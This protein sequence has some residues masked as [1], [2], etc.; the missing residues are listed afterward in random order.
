MKNKFTTKFEKVNLQGAAV[1]VKRNSEIFF[2]L[3]TII[4]GA[5]F[6]FTS[7]HEHIQDDTFIFLRYAQ[8]FV[9]GNGLVFN[10][11][12]YVEGF[13]GFLWLALITVL[14][15]LKEDLVQS[16]TLISMIFG[17]VTVYFAYKLST[18]IQLPFEAKTSEID[19]RKKIASVAFLFDLVPAILLALNG[20]VHYWAG[21][22]METMLYSTFITAGLYYFLSRDVKEKFF[23]YSAVY[24]TLA[25]LS[26]PEGLLVI[27][28]ILFHESVLL[29]SKNKSISAVAKKLSS[30]NYFKFI[31]IVFIPNF[32]L[33]IFR[34]LYYGYPLPNTFYAKAGLSPEYISSGFEYF[35]AFASAYLLWGVLLVFP[36]ILFKRKEVFGKISLLYSIVAVYSVYIIF[37]G[38][39]VLP[40]NRFF[41]PLLPVIYVL[42]GKALLQVYYFLINKFEKSSFVLQVL[43][44]TVLIAALGVYT[45]FSQADYI[46]KKEGLETNLVQKMT[47]SGKW[48]SAK[49]NIAGKPLTVAATTIGALSYYSESIV[50]DMLG[51]TDETIAHN[52]KPIE[53][54]S[55]EY[56]GWKERNYNVEY[57]LS[58]KPD[59]IIF[60][61]GLKPSAFAERALFTSEQFIKEY[62][63]YLIYYTPE[64]FYTNVYKRKPEAVLQ[65]DIIQSNN[66]PNY[67]KNYVN[68]YTE[69]LHVMPNQNLTDK[70][71]KLCKKLETIAPSNFSETYRLLGELY[72]RKGN[73]EEGLKYY[74]HA[75]AIDKFNTTA[76]GSLLGYSISKK[77]TNGIKYYGYILSKINPD[78]LAFYGLN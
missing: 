27:A 38:G 19:K 13:T 40:V 57:I 63:S 45:F 15:F 49:Q 28:I 55:G 68:L 67:S 48:F 54:I 74:K 70:T 61:T 56:T 66:N 16:V 50:I 75:V 3:L 41:I 2:F 72:T 65:A 34:L 9:H 73:E 25:S 78:V 1:S 64:R 33:I 47:A 18:A 58:R 32:L 4:I 77:D 12:E 46:R 44:P 69:I 35:G 76:L 43:I 17:G 23:I 53:E 62:Y 36:L 52:P 71:I 30:G 21:S 20:A 51:L 6:Y 10:P 42:L 29:F 8:N 22:G 59:F 5:Y 26:R 24:L 31:L 60:S 14:Q 7:L 37:I 11:G 39:D